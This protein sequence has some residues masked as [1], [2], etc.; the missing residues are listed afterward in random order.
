[1]N[2]SLTK[3]ITVTDVFDVAPYTECLK[4]RFAS[5]ARGVRSEE[6]LEHGER[7]RHVQLCEL[8]RQRVDVCNDLTRRR[9]HQR[10]LVPVQ[11]SESQL[12]FD[13]PDTLR[14]RAK[15]DEKYTYT[16]Q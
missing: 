14:D 10:I 15:E 4:P 5:F 13:K 9:S 12:G 2:C 6:C 8:P 16:A 3:A 1:M 7:A 11:Q